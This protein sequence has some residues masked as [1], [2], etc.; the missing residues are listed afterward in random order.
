MNLNSIN[1]KLIPKITYLAIATPP[2]LSAIYSRNRI[3]KVIEKNDKLNFF[4]VLFFSEIYI[5]LI[6]FFRD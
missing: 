5:P 6:S 3:K 4:T 2:M 1:F